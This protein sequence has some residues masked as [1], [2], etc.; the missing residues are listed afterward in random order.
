MAGADGPGIIGVIWA[1][2]TNFKWLTAPTF[3]YVECNVIEIDCPK[4]AFTVRPLLDSVIAS[5]L[6]ACAWESGAMF[7][8]NRDNAIRAIAPRTFV[9][10]GTFSFRA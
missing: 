9:G 1:S 6:A 3:Q 2:P 5:V 10:L 8:L 7:T 4:E